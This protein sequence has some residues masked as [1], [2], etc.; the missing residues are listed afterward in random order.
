MSKELTWDDMFDYLIQQENCIVQHQEIRVPNLHYTLGLYK[1]MIEKH[2]PE[3]RKINLS[4]KTLKG[5]LQ[6]I[7]QAHKKGKYENI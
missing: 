1:Q 6:R 4:C 2:N 7:Y 5:S 3:E